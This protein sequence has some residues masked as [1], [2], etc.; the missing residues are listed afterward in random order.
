MKE[1]FSY[2]YVGKG[3]LRFVK[4]FYL[5]MFLSILR[6]FQGLGMSLSTSLGIFEVFLGKTS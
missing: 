1:M 3:R 4:Y 5:L 6:V 2:N